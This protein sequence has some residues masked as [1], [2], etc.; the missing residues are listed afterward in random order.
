MVGSPVL[1]IAIP[2]LAAFVIP[3]IGMIWKELV[4]IIPGLVLAYMLIL[5]AT[6]LYYV[7][8][9]GTIVETIAGWQ[10][11]WGIN[12]VFSPLTGFL[13]TLMSALGFLVWLFSYRFKRNVDFEPA[14]KYFI[15]LM[16][17]IAGAIGIVI[18]GDIFNQFVFIEIT[19]I[20][21]Y[22]L[23]AFY[24]GRNSAEASFKYLMMGAMASSFLLVAIAILYSQLGTL[25]MADIASKMHT[26]NPTYKIIALIFF[27]TGIGIEAEIFP[28]NGWAPDAY[29]EAPGPVGAAF[30]GIVVKAGVYAIIRMIFTLFDVPG[31]YDFLIAIGLI[32]LIVAETSALRQE[33]LKR[34][35]AYSSIGQMG[36]VIVAFGIGTH[37]GVF[38]ALF[39][40]LNHAVIKPLL[41]FSGSSLVFNSKKKQIAEMNGLGKR[42]PLM[43]AF[44]S[45]GAFAIVG[46]PPFAGFWSK[47]SVLSAAANEGLLLIIV[48]I[49][50]VSVIEIV[51]YFRVVNRIFFQEYSKEQS[52]VPHR[53]RIN[54]MV[55]MFVL[56][57]AILIIGFYP[58]AVTGILH[59][60]AKDLMN[61]DQYINNVLQL[62]Q[63]L[64][65]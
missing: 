11:P 20:S 12:L 58:D 9:N 4:R 48:L 30:A 5:S 51:Y 14:K 39:L 40:M 45:L 43:A 63:S 24:T 10:A 18:T 47:L 1:L 55:A 54:A 46:L 60:A 32:T 3:L 6:L 65:R 19:G 34:M 35:L 49:L 23:T 21:A 33:K 38:A 15:F 36:L 64:T 28:L 7:S 53:P 59:N 62:G 13:A 52:V 61:T 37:E 22:A 29:T 42:M 56:A 25:N 44:F 26:M 16:L 17:L 2:L 50:I 57:I 41:F 31:A 8:Y 27:I